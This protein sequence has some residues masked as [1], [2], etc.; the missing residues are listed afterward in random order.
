[1][2]KIIYVLHPM[3]E[4]AGGVNST[5]AKFINQFEAVE[6]AEPLCRRRRG[7]ISEGYTHTVAWNPIVNAPSKMKSMTAAAIPAPCATLVLF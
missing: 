5:M 4:I 7:R 1:M 3:F 6:I 2:A